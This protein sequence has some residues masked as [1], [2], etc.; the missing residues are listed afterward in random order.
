MSRLP[1]DSRPLRFRYRPRHTLA[2][3][4][5]FCALLFVSS[6]LVGAGERPAPTAAA[7]I[8]PSADA[9]AQLDEAYARD[10]LPLVKTYC[11]DCHS[12]ETKEGELD[13]EQFAGL[14]NVR[15]KP[16]AWQ[17]VAE[18]LDNGEMPPKDA[19]QPTADER[20]ALRGWVGKYLDAEARADA[21][22]P[23][24]VVLRRLSNVEYTYT[25]R[26]LTGVATLDPARE[27][28][29]DGAAGEGF[30]NTG[31]ALVMSPALLTKY[32]D[33]GKQVAEHAVLLPDGIRFSQHTTRRDWTNETLDEIR[34]FYRPYTDATGA[35]RVNLQGLVWDTNEGGRLPLDKFLA[36]TIAEREAILAGKKTIEAAAAEHRVNSKYLDILWRTLTARDRSPLV[37]PIRT[38][39]R[40][41][42]A[43][44]VPAI[45][46]D[47]GRWQ[48]A[49][50]KFSSVGHIGKVGGPKA[51]ME[52][53][54]PVLARQEVRLKLAPAAD[55]S[56]DAVFYLS[57]TP[58]FA[59][60][61][62]AAGGKATVVWQ[63]PRLV[64]PGKGDI[65]L[66]DLRA[67][68]EAWTARRGRM[69]ASTAKSLAAAAEV[70]DASKP[71]NVEEL[72]KR[73]GV[74]AD[75]LAAWLE[76][77]GLESTGEA[78]ID[79]HLTK[80]TRGGG[81]YDFISSWAAG[82][83]PSV[84]ANSSDRH[85]RIPGNMKPHGFAVHPSPALNVA[86]GWRSP[87]S[88]KL[89]I[90]GT[91]VHAHPECGNGVVWSLE[92]RRGAIRRRLAEG[93]SHG[94][95][96][97]KVGPIDSLAVLP[98]DFVSLVVGPRDGNH[99]CD[100]T[101][102]DLVL[103]D[104]ADAKR[105]WNLAADVSPDILAGNPHADRLGNANVWH[106]YSEPVAT[107]AATG[108]AIPAGSLLATWFA[109]TSADERRQLAEGIEKL[110]AAGP[111]ADA[112]HPDAVLYRQLASFTGPLLRAARDDVAQL[113]AAGKV[114]LGN[115]RWG[116]DAAQFA[117]DGSLSVAAPSTVE[118]RLPGMLA[119]GWEFAATA[120]LAGAEGGTPSVQ[121]Q[122]TAA[123][124]EPVSAPRPD[125]PILVPASG[126][127]R[128]AA[129]AALDAFRQVFPPALCYMKIVPVDEVVTL[130]LFYREDDHL[131]RL[132]LDDAAAAR[133][134][135]L[136]DEL[137]YVSQDALTLVDAYL[138]LMEYATQDADPSVFEPL[139]KPINDRA[140]AFRRRLAETEPQHVE[141]VLKFAE[142]AYRR[143]LVAGETAE[144]RG[145]YAKLRREEVSHDEAVRLTLA[146]VLVSPAFLYKIETPPEGNASGPVNDWEFA[147]RLSYFLWSS[148]PDAELRSLA[149]SGKLRDEAVL[150]GQAR[151][152]LRDPKVRRLASEFACQ[153]LHI[154]D[155]AELEEKSEK[156]FPTFVSVRGAIQE[157]AIQFF[158][159]LFARGGSVLEIIDADH[160][161]VNE[162]LAKHYGIEGVSGDEW[163]RVDGMKARG[164]GGVLAQ[165]STLAKQ[166]GASR[167]SPI[168]RGTWI[169]EVL[170]GERL[171]RPPKNV[172]QLPDDEAAT[173]NL[174]VRQLVERHS[175]DPKCA[176]CHMRFDHY[177]F[178]LENFDAIGRYREKD[179][180]DRPIDAHVK[181]PDGFEMNGVAGLREYLVTKRRDA[182]VRQFC[183]K[184]LGYALGRAVQL[185]D[186]PLLAAMQEELR[187]KNYDVSLAVE[188]IVLSRQFREIRGRDAAAEPEAH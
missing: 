89:R 115:A 48:G 3:V 27:F 18:M 185:S 93:V 174:T 73:H 44:D 30:T 101:A 6:L 143:P 8:A 170:L 159:D 35:T 134:D 39:W 79:S 172:P 100:L 2:F 22:D 36:A 31:N 97:V 45:V 88:A 133:L 147:T 157:E 13:L 98:G 58:V 32:L 71:A 37:E 64:A 169:S 183:R 70:R 62:N 12:T 142:L 53:V 110:L 152:M 186:E 167:T 34:G 156:H 74:D 171:P 33:A 132:M 178:A 28:P 116:V 173:A 23:G 91:V 123:E 75:S 9:F 83:L 108:P 82:D 14:A 25:L 117:A 139:R 175:S 67:V 42:K 94:G 38:K 10:V 47:I 51:W 61:G 21:G 121:V 5:G 158:A 188:K 52:P 96:P 29:V 111:P 20:K 80:A 114:A 40:T 164:R 120:T 1:L 72:A 146:R 60:D 182:V 181:T 126:A 106:F 66:A 17:R 103:V 26:D 137:R 113:R 109:A 76:F 180:G 163:R 122:A 145:L 69:F 162:T 129:I 90:E 86:T 155:V 127:A 141:A 184:L 177:G 165:A 16:A 107:S 119:D 24:R 84:V 153:W 125:L 46:T 124:P 15:K 102:V 63:Q 131:R 65:P 4:A 148:A 105:T 78:K 11:L 112:K 77:L 176:V 118:V 179:L 68:S 168:L 81:G 140:A 7:P 43:E 154:R 57:A 50:W 92:H 54:D 136:W 135:R 130:T 95:A 187:A 166:S 41:A 160:T 99:S 87:V 138:Q 161:F 85:V 128:D 55:A 149:A 151:R 59:G 49:L 104:T 150:R 19:D 56:G 144:L